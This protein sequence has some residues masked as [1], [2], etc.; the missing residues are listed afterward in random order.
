MKLSEIK[1]MIE[2][3]E[4]LHYARKDLEKL[5]RQSVEEATKS[6]VVLRSCL[7]MNLPESIEN[8][9]SII[10]AIVSKI[11]DSSVTVPITEATFYKIGNLLQSEIDSRI[12]EIKIELDA[13]G[14]DYDDK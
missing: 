10:S 12:T 3:H 8:R 2:E 14:I 1:E 7:H 9:L 5:L 4:T 6:G 11:K 13:L